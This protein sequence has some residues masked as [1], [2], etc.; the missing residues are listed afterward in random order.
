MFNQNI[1][2][3]KFDLNLSTTLSSYSYQNDI[4]WNDIQQFDTWWN[5]IQQ[6]DIVQN[7]TSERHSIAWHIQLND[8]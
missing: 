6:N 4:N 7:Y 8:T 5:D 3:N 1:M 2:S